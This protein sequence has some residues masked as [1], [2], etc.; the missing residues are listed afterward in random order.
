MSR[1]LR[2]RGSRDKVM[3]KS[4]FIFQSSNGRSKKKIIFSNT[5]IYLVYSISVFPGFRLVFFCFTIGYLV[6]T[7][8]HRGGG[9]EI[10][11]AAT[12][13]LDT[14][15]LGERPDILIFF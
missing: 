9:G 13:N 14:F 15:C 6:P 8:Y 3:L 2:W 11:P 7:A 5:S 4:I 12:L 1:D 10:L